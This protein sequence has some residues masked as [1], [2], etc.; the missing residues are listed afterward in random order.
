[1][2][3]GS[4]LGKWHKVA[5]SDLEDA[6]LQGQALK[7][8]IYDCEAVYL[9]RRSYV[10][11]AGALDESGMFIG[12]V[13]NLMSVP[14]GVVRDKTL[15]HFVHI[16]EITLR[17]TPLTDTK[18]GQIE[19]WAK[20]VKFR[21]GINRYIGGLEAFSPPLYCGQTNKLSVRLRSHLKGESHFGRAVTDSSILSWSDLNL[22]YYAIDEVSTEVDDK[23]SAKDR[24]Q[25]LELLTTSLTVSGYVQRR[26]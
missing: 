5:G 9:W 2:S 19:K 8:I 12:W 18:K 25:L 16:D 14:F 13:D 17:P 24:R 15:S 11:P 3:D 26:G 22:Y 23:E 21:R 10:S 1:M 4:I 7:S 6:M 20:K